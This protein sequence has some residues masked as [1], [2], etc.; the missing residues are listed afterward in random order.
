MSTAQQHTESTE[1]LVFDGQQ[2]GER[3]LYTIYPHW[4]RVV[5][6]WFRI[7]SATVLA[8]FIWQYASPHLKFVQEE[9]QIYGYVAIVLLAIF[10]FWWI[11]HQCKVARAYLTDRRIVR[12]EAAFPVFEKRRALLWSEVTKT[13]AYCKNTFLRGLRVGTLRVVPF[14]HQL[15]DVEIIYTFYVEDLVSYIDKIVYLVK[16]KSPEL[17]TLR[18][19]VAKPKGKRYA[20]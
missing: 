6:G 11:W 5:V 19:F 10:G 3:V 2:E 1:D 15:D 16:S 12:F 4:L 17:E 7:A 13:S 20:A 14:V 8:W 9:Q 18:P